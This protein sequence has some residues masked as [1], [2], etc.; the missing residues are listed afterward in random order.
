MKNKES[1]NL[2]ASLQIYSLTI[3]ASDETDRVTKRRDWLQSYIVAYTAVAVKMMHVIAKFLYCLIFH[4][5]RELSKWKV[6]LSESFCM[7]SVTFQ[8][9]VEFAIVNFSVTQRTLSVWKVIRK[10]PFCTESITFRV[11]SES[12]AYEHK[13]PLSCQRFSYSMSHDYTLAF[14]MPRPCSSM[15]QWQH[16]NVQYQQIL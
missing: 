9:G 11:E 16:R 8:M 1:I 10:Q 4:T 5:E 13:K 7:E 14:R 3:M 6:N 15:C 12:G 2:W